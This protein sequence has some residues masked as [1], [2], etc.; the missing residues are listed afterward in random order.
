MC[1]L[2]G[3]HLSLS[4]ILAHPVNYTYFYIYIHI[5]YYRNSNA[6]IHLKKNEK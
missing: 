5:Y 3:I 4:Q 6:H 2:L 1:F